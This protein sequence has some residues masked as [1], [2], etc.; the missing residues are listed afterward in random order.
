M[1]CY[2]D[3]ANGGLPC[4][5]APSS[6][7]GIG[8][9]SA[10]APLMAAIQALVN[11][12]W[13][14]RAGNPNPT[15][16]SIAKTEF[17][18]KGNPSC[19]SINVTAGSSCVFNDITQGDID[20]NCQFNG[21]VF[22]ADCYLPSGTYGA[23]STQKV[24]SLTLTKGGSGYTT[25]PNCAVTVLNN[26]TKY[27]SPTGST[28]FAGGVQAKCTATISGGVVTAVTLTNAGSGYTGVPKC[29]IGGGGGKGATCRVTITPTV[30]A[31]SY[32]PAFGA[33]PGWDMAT[34]LGSVNAF[35]LV[36]NT[37]W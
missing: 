5:G 17:G 25:T 8:G 1:I 29:T 36:F 23:I 37:A 10:S 6:W 13:S 14:I 16:Y 2:S 24:S 11:Q 30:R 28:I 9:T 33:T 20:V 35:N 22:K 32:Q 21:N 7:I 27:A 26:K 31:N 34:G 3:A 19:Y 15:Y 4:T 12:H 18:T